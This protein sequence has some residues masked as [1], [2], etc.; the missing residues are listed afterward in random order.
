MGA[1]HPDHRNREVGVRPACRAAPRPAQV[2]VWSVGY[3]ADSRP[4]LIVPGAT[5]REYCEAHRGLLLAVRWSVDHDELRA[6]IRYVIASG[7]LPPS[8]PLSDWAPGGR[9]ARTMRIVI[10][11]SLPE[12][13]SICGEASPTIFYIYSDQKAV[14]IHAACEALWREEGEVPSG[15]RRLS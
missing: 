7:K 12:L 3:P 4:R 1:A 2:A 6:W 13:C 8:P 15:R 10:E 11:R 14:R 9:A 5:M